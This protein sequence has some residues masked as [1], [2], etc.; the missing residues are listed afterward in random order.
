MAMA[1]VS[2]VAMA[3]PV[4]VTVTVAVLVAMHP[5]VAFVLGV[6]VHVF[7]RIIVQAR[8]GRAERHVIQNANGSRSGS[9]RRGPAVPPHVHEQ[10]VHES[11]GTTSRLNGAHGLRTPTKHRD[12]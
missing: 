11:E 7:M 2:A 5:F 12:R 4:V 10:R 8:V 6:M 9:T 1:V 3:V